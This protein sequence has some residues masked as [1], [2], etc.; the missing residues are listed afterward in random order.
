MLTAA[1]VEISVSQL[2]GELDRVILRFEASKLPSLVLTLRPKQKQQRPSP[3]R[4]NH[5][6]G[7]YPRRAAQV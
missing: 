4:P 7:N 5:G 2:V 3:A 6:A 1:W